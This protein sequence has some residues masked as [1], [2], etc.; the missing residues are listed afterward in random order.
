MSRSA[1]Y[2]VN[3]TT[4]DVAQ[5]GNIS[6]G[7]TIRRYGCNLS[8]SGNAITIRGQGY[9]DVAINVTLAPTATGDVAVTLYKD[10][11]AVPG[12]TST[13]SVSTANN[14]A[15]LPVNCLIRETC[16]DTTSNLTL[17]LTGTAAAVSNVAAVVQKI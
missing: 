7:T 2:T 17:V 15:T 1:I 6:F 8:M 5:N 14:P 9:Y 11:V 13:G 3:N 12:A 10:G 4:Q 16:C